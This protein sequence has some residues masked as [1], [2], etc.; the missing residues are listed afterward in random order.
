MRREAYVR[1]NNTF[2]HRKMCSKYENWKWNRTIFR[3]F[4]EQIK[5]SLELVIYFQGA[6][7]WWMVV[8]TFAS[9]DAPECAEIFFY[10]SSSI[11]RAKYKNVNSAE[12]IQCERMNEETD[13]KSISLSF[14]GTRQVHS[15]K[16]RIYF[17]VGC[18]QRGDNG[19]IF[20]AKR[21]ETNSVRQ[22]H[23]ARL[24]NSSTLEFR[25]AIFTPITTQNW[26]SFNDFYCTQAY[27]F[28]LNVHDKY[29]LHIVNWPSRFAR[30]IV[31]YTY[32][33]RSS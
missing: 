29:E 27:E 30:G 11:A 2:N 1:D 12:R 24:G 20:H 8:A 31:Q 23:L 6:R 10:L 33:S 22:L 14:A 19:W 13:K 15:C 25:H 3:H 21:G 17:P 7:L 26:M 9:K 28:R 16:K 4:S 32:I 5:I 18:L